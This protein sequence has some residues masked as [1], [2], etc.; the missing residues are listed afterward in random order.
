MAKKI[1]SHVMDLNKSGVTF[2][3]STFADIGSTAV[4]FRELKENVGHDFFTQE[5]LIIRTASGGGGTLLV[6]TTDYVLSEED[7]LLSSEV[8]AAI[9]STRHIYKKIQIIN[10]SYQTGSLYV[11]GKW[12]ADGVDATFFNAISPIVET[13]TADY[14]I[15]DTDY[16]KVY[17]VTTGTATKKITLPTVTD[18]KNLKIKIVKID[19]GYGPVMVDGE[20]SETI[21]GLTHIFLW[22]RYDCVELMSTGSEWI[23]INDFK[24]YFYSGWISRSDWTN[25]H[26]GF[27]TI[28]YDT[29]V[30][31]VQIG[32]KVTGSNG[33]YGIVI[34][35]NGSTSCVIASCVTVGATVFADNEALSFDLSGA[36]ALVNMG[37]GLKNVDSNIYHGLSRNLKDISV[38]L[39][40]STDGT[41]NNSFRVDVVNYNGG[42]SGNFNY[43]FYQVD[44]NNVKLQTGLDGLMSYNDSGTAAGISTSD[45]FYNLLIKI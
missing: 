12:I 38:S 34:Y 37:S 23:I 5:D 36:T 15:T 29:L 32:D 40:I 21:N 1:V 43:L 11:S 28:V 24:P 3:D 45:Y 25:V 6:E 18:N 19:S 44:S 16:Y 42:T 33:S 31:T 14:T 4:S 41:E 26:L 30:G 20:G 22:S 2:T 9:G 27:A 39:N 7:V 10:A 13:K 8:T 35:D 17:S